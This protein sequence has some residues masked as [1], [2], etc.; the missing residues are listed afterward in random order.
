M[1]TLSLEELQDRKQCH[2]WS[3]ESTGQACEGKVLL[4]RIK[5]QPGRAV[6]TCGP[7][8]EEA[9]AGGSQ[10]QSQ[11]ELAARSFFQNTKQSI[12]K[13]IDSKTKKYSV[14]QEEGIMQNHA[15]EGQ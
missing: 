6:H 10:I 2:P 12:L 8:T 9:E 15:H 4:V 3:V 11:P 7:S 13:T 5:L 1:N 14:F